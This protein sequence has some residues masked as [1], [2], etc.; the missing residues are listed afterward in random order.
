M[1][2][3]DVGSLVAPN[4][5]S[6]QRDLTSDQRDP[7]DRQSLQRNKTR[8]ISPDAERKSDYSDSDNKGEKPMHHLQPDLERSHVGQ[9]PRVAPR[10]NFCKRS[11]AGIGYPRAVC[12]GKIKNRKVPVLMAHRCPERKLQVNRE[13]YSNRKRFDLRELQ[14]IDSQIRQCLPKICRDQS[15]N[16]E[17]PEKCL[18]DT[19]V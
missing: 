2:R 17:Q 1:R 6:S 14:R 10:I 3:R 12:C 11:C 18:R 7:P 16:D 4:C 9:S 15:N 8:R 19:R 13:R 5:P